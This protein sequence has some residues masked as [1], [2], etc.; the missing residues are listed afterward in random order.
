MPYLCNTRE[1]QEEV[2][3]TYGD[4]DQS[5]FGFKDFREGITNAGDDHFY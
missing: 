5:M 3:S 1:S 4:S 2:Y